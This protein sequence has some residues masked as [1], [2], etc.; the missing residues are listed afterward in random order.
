M[1]R[2]AYTP[3]SAMDEFPDDD[4]REWLDGCV[5]IEKIRATRSGE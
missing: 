1:A 5:R 3:D 2:F 4:R